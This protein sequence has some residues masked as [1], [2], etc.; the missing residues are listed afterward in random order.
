MAETLSIKRRK[1]EQSEVS[2]TSL[3]REA[4][5]LI[6]K[7]SG[8]D[9]TDYNLHDPGITILEQLIYSITDLIYRTEFAVEDF[10]ADAEGKPDIETLGL[11]ESEQIMSCRPTTVLDYRKLLLNAVPLIDNVWV[12]PLKGVNY[13]GLYRISARLSQGL[14]QLEKERALE[15]LRATYLGA[16]NLCEDLGEI[17]LVKSVD[18]ELC[19]QIEVG[20]ARRPVDILAEIYFNCARSLADSVT[21]TGYDQLIEN[22]P[23]LDQLFDGPLTDHGFFRD[24]DL[25]EQQA[26]FQVS[27]LFSVINAI[28]AVDHVRQLYLERDGEVY[29][30]GLKSVDTDEA[31]DLLIPRQASDI[32]IVLTTAGRELPIALDEL[33]ARYDELVLKYHSS[34][35]TRQDSSVLYES[36]SAANRSLSQY[37][38]LQNQFPTAYGINRFGVPGSASVEIKARARQL[39]AYLLIFEQLLANFLANLDSIK[40]LFSVRTDIQVS[41]SCQ[42]LDDRQ[43]TDLYAVYPAAANAINAQIVAGFDN[44][45]ERKSRLLDYLLALYG[46]GFS[47]NSLRHYNFY[48]RK[49]EVDEVIVA[50]KAAYLQSIVE[51]GRDRAAGFDYNAT[52]EGQSGLAMR[53]AM[54]LGFEQRQTIFLVDELVEQGIELSESDVDGFEIVSLEELEQSSEEGFDQPSLI[55]MGPTVSPDAPGLNHRLLATG[56]DIERYRVGKRNSSTEYEL[57]LLIDNKDCWMLGS[58][59]DKSLATEAANNLRHYLLKLNKS[60]EGLHIVEHILLRP[61]RPNTDPETW[62]N[63]F[64]SFRISVIFPSWTARCQNKQFR[65]LAEE[66]VRL[67]TPAHIWPEFYWLD[68]EPM[69]E[70]ETLYCDWLMFKNDRQAD[71]SSLDL[72]AERL[73]AFLRRKERM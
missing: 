9:W 2:F 69:A 44:Y 56:I 65:M 73:I 34:R 32:K 33:T 58:Y 42:A 52:G 39:K 31:Y 60:S 53:V 22:T 4:I 61:H 3:R 11:H 62:E 13:R 47:Q 5:Q 20:S 37:Y 51:L 57:G 45:C 6:E 23:P 71:R 10:L 16:R 28:E 26:D 38:S 21:I 54:L 40:T 12:G 48:Y 8:Q 41:Y 70:F 24:E 66:T 63:D 68:L 14:D 30:D 29:Q 1:P 15:Q 46:E 55:K 50:N 25:H 43:I 35:S 67:N 49:D 27:T 18:Y 59:H 36:V 17:E 19:A 7:I 72:C 64:F